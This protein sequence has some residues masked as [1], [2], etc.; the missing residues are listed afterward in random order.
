MGNIVPVTSPTVRPTAPLIRS[1][2]SAPAGQCVEPYPNVQTGDAGRAEA[3]FWVGMLQSSGS[4]DVPSKR[5]GAISESKL[6][7][8]L[9]SPCPHVMEELCR[10][11][12]RNCRTRTE[13]DT[14][15]LY[16]IPPTREYRVIGSTKWMAML[17]PLATSVR[18][19]R[20]QLDRSR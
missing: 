18:R 13:T 12:G 3:R 16:Y 7:E 10:M 1:D 8:G 20:P 11:S 19:G 14:A 9:E 15:L 4:V 2:P 17:H 5:K 6:G